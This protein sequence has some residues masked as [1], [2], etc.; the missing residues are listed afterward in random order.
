MS[1]L[2]SFG[3]SALVVSDSLSL[4]DLE[5]EN[6]KTELFASVDLLI[7]DTVVR[8]LRGEVVVQT[9][10]GRQ[11]D[12][13]SIEG[14]DRRNKTA[15][16]DIFSIERQHS[17]GAWFLP[18]KVSIKTG[19]VNL[20][21]IF[22]KYPRFATGLAW[23][24]RARILLADSPAAVFLHVAIEPLFEQLFQPFELRGRI[25]GSKSREDQIAAWKSVDELV[26]AL[27]LN[28]EK[29]LR[30]M[31]YGGGWSRLRAAE[32]IEAKQNVLRALSTQA[33]EQLAARYRA[34]LLRPLIDRYYSKSK[35]GQARRK[36]VL[37]RSLEKTLSGFFGGDW[38]RFLQYLGETPHPD[39]EIA[40]A[41]PE[42]QLFVG[43]SKSAA[44]VAS[45]VGVATEEV[46]R[47]LA[48]YWETSKDHA[49]V[50]GSPVDQRVSVLRA[51]WKHFDEIHS[52]QESGMPA[53]WG[54]VEEDRSIRLTWE[55]PDWYN[56][57]AYRKLLPPDLITEIERLWA[58]ILLPRWPER[59]VSE[60]SPHALMAESFGPALTFWHGSAL[61][62]WFVCEGPMSRTD[63]ASMPTYYQD[64]L[65]QLEQ[66]GCPI[67]LNL[68]ADLSEAEKR[69]G[70][71]EPIKTNVSTTDVAGVTLE[72]SISSG[73]RRSGFAKLRDVLTKHRRTWADQYLET[74]LRA[75]WET[76]LREAA[77]L[78]A[79]MIADKGKP[80]TPKQ[81]ARHAATATNHWFGG[82]MSAFYA[83]IGEKSMVRPERVTLLATDRIGFAKRVFE[84]L[85]G[86]PFERKTLVANREEGVAQAAEQDRHTKFGWLAEE[87]LRFVQLE[88]ALGRP[89]E[90]K[91]FGAAGFEYRSSVLAPDSQEAWSKYVAVMEVARADPGT[92]R[93]DVLS[94]DRTSTPASSS[95][96]SPLLRAG[97]DD[98]Q[99]DNPA[100]ATERR[101]W[102]RRLLGR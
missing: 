8:A 67:N 12:S 34:Y 89:P 90:L 83:A 4:L 47:A 10:R 76:E 65:R 29:E 32:Q 77:R 85:G 59:I 44:A 9:K 57:R 63:I 99:A 58:S 95:D 66:L 45:E 46:E 28:L 69:L 38:L 72:M 82:D 42:A 96:P 19:L 16:E 78:H 79:Q 30:V 101:P 84:A 36:Q 87:S 102:L 41:I 52:R 15:L 94:D 3:R 2:E 18:E 68:F 13:V 1:E 7:A 71:P 17:R 100:E 74:Y 35:N 6:G 5:T 50:A 31:R 80:P 27:G 70:P 92:R 55:G 56:A 33:N 93:G 61:T 40:A 73:S 54:I 88:E 97:S 21:S 64:D 51:Y 60:L 22:A 75:R 81:F 39:E 43:G 62:A 86:K 14:L 49:T 25:A 37:T 48:T 98:A 24:E 26:S 20:P 23:E 11:A 53:L 91:E